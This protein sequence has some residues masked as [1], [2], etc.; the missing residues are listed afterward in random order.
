[1]RGK[2][3]SDRHRPDQRRHDRHRHQCQIR[4]G[5]MLYAV[6]SMRGTRCLHANPTS[7]TRARDS[8]RR[9]LRQLHQQLFDLGEPFP[10]CPRRYVAPD[11]RRCYHLMREN[12]QNTGVRECRNG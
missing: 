4:E 6:K 9:I 11:P 12:E 7:L 5:G 8:A 10:A 3:R 2:R 1:V